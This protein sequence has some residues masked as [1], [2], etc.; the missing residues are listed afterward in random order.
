MDN[1]YYT[2][3][4]LIRAGN[5]NGGTC[6]QV[7]YA[8]FSANTRTSG[9]PP[10]PPV[11]CGP[12]SNAILQPN[13]LTGL[14]LIRNGQQHF[15][16][17]HGH[18]TANAPQGQGPP[19]GVICC[20]QPIYYISA[21]SPPAT[22]YN[23]P[24][25]LPS[26]TN[27]QNMNNNGNFQQQQQQ[28]LSV[29]QIGPGQ[30]SKRRNYKTLIPNHMKLKPVQSSPPP[31]IYQNQVNNHP[32]L[33]ATSSY[34]DPISPPAKVVHHVL[35]RT[36]SNHQFFAS[37]DMNSVNEEKQRND[38][39]LNFYFEKHWRP[40]EEED[41][42]GSW[43]EPAT[44]YGGTQGDTTNSSSWNIVERQQLPHKALSSQNLQPQMEITPGGFDRQPGAGRLTSSPPTILKQQKDLEVDAQII[45]LANGHRDLEIR[46]C[47]VT[48]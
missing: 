32:K 4:T 24:I 25:L 15:Q 18:Q 35:T 43:K 45:T 27:K 46:L 31:V 22:V 38:K 2:G 19:P 1:A 16:P 30:G 48:S 3:A 9:T 37:E 23:T 5:L 6:S 13:L 34:P 41:D 11:S 17:S 33:T 36:S 14:P 12:G 7:K 39:L 47:Y 28:C 42:Q 44:G 29:K 10:L 26:S 20:F 40:R 8:S 21:P